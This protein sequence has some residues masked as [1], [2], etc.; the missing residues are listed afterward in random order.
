LKAPS[1]L[2]LFAALSGGCSLHSLDYLQQGDDSR[3][4]GAAG[5]AGAGGSGGSVAGASTSPTLAGA[6]AAP[7]MATAG[8]STSMAG[9]G[10]GGNDAATARCDDALVDVD[11]TD[12]DCGGRAC[13]P[14]EDEKRCIT[15]TD[16]ISGICTNQVCQAPSCVDLA[17]NGD[18][19]DFNCGGTC[20]PCS[21][22]YSCQVGTDC[23]TGACLSSVCSAPNCDGPTPDAGCPLLVDKT[24]YS[25]RP[26]DAPDS[27]ID[28][29][30]LGVDNGV[31]MQ[32]YACH[33]GA[34]QT[35]LALAGP[36]GTFALRNALSGKCLQVRANS[37]ASGALIEQASCTGQS[38]QQFLPSGDGTGLKLVI[39]SSGL[40]LDVAGASDSSDGQ[41]LVQNIDDG[42]LDMRWTA[43]KAPGGG[44]VTLNALGQAGVVL[45]DDETVIRAEASVGPD[46]Q[47]KVEPGLASPA[48]VS[49]ESNAQPGAY[50][51]HSDALL[52]TDIFDG[53][54]NFSQD[55]TFCLRPRL[56][57][58]DAAS[59]GLESF[60]YPGNYVSASDG[61]VRLLTFV[62]SS[63]F[64]QLATWVVAKPN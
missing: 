64:R 56:S 21:I 27:C 40:S 24:A 17:C 59:H 63:P 9:A 18:E 54:S 62:D 30:G 28:G 55:A 48:C 6:G 3:S 23:T 5:T 7:V 12:V 45:R 38:E 4:M 60:N 11:E 16:C 35:F 20:A 1:R 8:T 29:V 15:G 34:N 50:L 22:G 58:S 39:Q 19:T 14:C 49:F 2:A 13:G 46:S 52:W 42:S 47:W 37:L 25:L 53:S 33:G 51:R 44:V 31:E 36:G 61:R 10:A 43:V 32:Q 26:A 41:R 57:G